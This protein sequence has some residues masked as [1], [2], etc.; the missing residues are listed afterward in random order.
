VDDLQPKLD[1]D[2]RVVR[3]SLVHYNT[4]EEVNTIIDILKRVLE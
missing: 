1:P 2:D 4:I 3:I